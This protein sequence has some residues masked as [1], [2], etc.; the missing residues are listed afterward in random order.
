MRLSKVFL[1]SMVAALGLDALL[2]I[3][4]ILF[5]RYGPDEELLASA[6]LF[7]AFC[8]VALLCAIVLEKRRLAIL[9]WTGIACSA[10]ALALWLALIWLDSWFEVR[11]EARI[12]RS[13][14]TFTT[15]AVL[16]GQCGLLALLRL[17]QKWARAVRVATFAT[18]ASLGG[19]IVLFVWLSDAWWMDEDV[20]IRIIGVAAILTACGTVVTPIL[21]K[22]QR[23]RPLMPA[24]SVPSRVQVSLTCPRCGR[25]QSLAAGRAA[26]AGCGLRIEINVEEPRCACGYLLHA[27]QGDRCPE[28]GRE[29]AAD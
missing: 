19:L 10:A 1:W 15:A 28:C 12:V 24:E 23:V 2:G 4:A 14:F 20:M 17:D 26:C 5:P 6:A 3:A 7:A 27:L 16:I 8:L 22:V 11:W 21:W 9:M 13:G 29:I 18:S 25:T